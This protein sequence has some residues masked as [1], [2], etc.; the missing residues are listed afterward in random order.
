MAEEVLVS[1]VRATHADGHYPVYLMDIYSLKGL[2]SHGGSVAFGFSD[3][4]RFGHDVQRL[5]Q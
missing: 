2:W 3:L 1:D 4:L 5:E